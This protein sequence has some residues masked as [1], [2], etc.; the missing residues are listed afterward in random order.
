MQK[1]IKHLEVLTVLVVSIAIGVACKLNW[2]DSSGWP[3]VWAFV[4]GA[5]ALYFQTVEHLLTWPIYIV[6]VAIYAYVFHQG[7]LF[8]D[9][10]LQILYVFLSIH[11]WASWQ[12]GGEKHSNLKIS[13]LKPV[14]WVP[15][16]LFVAGGTALYYPS[17]VARQDPAPIID[18]LLTCASVVTQILLNRKIYE[19][20]ALWVAIDGAYV[21]LY[22]SRKYYATSILFVAFTILAA[23]GWIQWHKRLKKP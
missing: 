14:L 9:R 12:R 4:V 3:E 16:I 8:A 18:G 17:L 7:R 19:N 15:V 10:D 6:S 13:R 1:P 2:P 11:G 23:V 22:M 21:W 5:V 20:W